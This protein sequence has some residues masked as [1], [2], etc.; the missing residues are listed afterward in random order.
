[1]G[2]SED[3]DA[4]ITV[5][6]QGSGKKPY[7]LKCV[8]GIPSCNC[9]SWRNA[10]GPIDKRTCKHLKKVRGEKAEFSRLRETDIEKFTRGLTTGGAPAVEV[11]ALIAAE[12][13]EGEELTPEAAAEAAEGTDVLLAQKWTPDIDPTGKW[14]SEKLNGVRAYWNGQ[15]FISRLGNGFFAPEW[16]KE[17]LPTTPLDGEL[18]LSRKKGALQETVSIVRSAGGAERWKGLTYLVF[19][20]PKQPGSFERRMEHLSSLQSAPHLS[21]VSHQ[22]CTGFDHLK[23][24]LLRVEALGGEGLM[25]R[26]PGSAYDHGRSSTLLKVKTFHDAEGKV[27][28]HKPGK[29]KHK[30]RL[31]ALVIALD[32]GETFDVGTGFS[33]NERRKPPSVGTVIT[34]R[35]TET[36]VRGIPLC[37]SYVGIRSE[38]S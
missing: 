20:A 2:Q 23:D 38:L 4:G 18:W 16:F 7:E 33:D 13:D 37:A 1:M 3:L 26:E 11:K 36:T 5:Y 24:E 29:G 8:N 35:Y 27:V 14:M 25:L 15:R 34:Y 21:L 9:P 30:G 19:D 6:V 31:G 12:K 17:G 28:E 10:G 32:N 22:V